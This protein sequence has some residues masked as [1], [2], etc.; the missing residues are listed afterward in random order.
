[1]HKFTDRLT[2]IRGIPAYEILGCTKDH[3]K[4]FVVFRE[5]M[6]GYRSCRNLYTSIY[7]HYQAFG[8]PERLY[9]YERAKS[10]KIVL[11]YANRDE[12]EPIFKMYPNFQYI[13]RKMLIFRKDVFKVLEHWKAHPDMEILLN[14]KMM[15]LAMNKTFFRMGMERQKEIVRFAL[16]SGENVE[17]MQLCDILGAMKYH[18]KPLDYLN[19]RHEKAKAVTY[20]E[21]IHIKEK[22]INMKDFSIYKQRLIDYF[23]ERLKDPYWTK[24][25]DDKDFIAKEKRILKECMHLDELKELA[26]LKEKAEAY[27]KAI[28]KR[29]LWNGTFNGLSVYVPTEIEDWQAQASALK[30]CLIR[31]DYIDQVTKHKCIV[32]FI[33]DK[34]KPIATAE[35][36]GKE[37][38]LSQFY[39]NEEKR[40]IKP[41]KRARIALDMFMDKFIRKCA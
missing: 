10:P 27:L 13:A 5:Y 39:C 2:T 38:K 35:F 28:G 9:K 12:L 4:P 41:P 31:N 6:T 30:Q 8:E 11:E 20:S 18:C 23:P 15:N 14:L 24:P 7:N 32:V 36:K 25:K 26:K 19:Y 1:M 16:N 3:R 33:K 22:R 34:D 21:W 17:Y 29:S 37:M 40:N